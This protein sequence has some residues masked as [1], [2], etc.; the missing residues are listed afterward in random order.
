MRRYY[1]K[2]SLWAACALAMLGTPAMA[3]KDNPEP[4]TAIEE[5]ADPLRLAAAEK[6]VDYLFPLGTYERM[7]RGTMD[8]MISQMMGSMMDMPASDMA[9]MGGANEEQAE[10]LGQRSMAEM[11]LD[12]DPHFHE[13]TDISM[14]VMMDEMVTLMSSMEPQIRTALSGIYARKFTLQQ[15][16]EMNTFFAT[17]T[18]T[19][20]ARDYMMVFV[21]KDMM[22]TM[23]GF[24]PEMMKVM[25]DI[26]KKVEEATAHLPPLQMPGYDDIDGDK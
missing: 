18:G 1:R 7:M 15:L 11:A 19:A 4:A 23:M 24:V 10:A 14:K 22:S 12:A 9:K 25:P 8:K 13:R 6:A 17:D 21:D 20:F 16:G 26:Q 5:I 3:S 2:T